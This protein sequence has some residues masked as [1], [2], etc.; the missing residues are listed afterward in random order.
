MWLCINLCVFLLFIQF[1]LIAHRVN[2]VNVF[3]EEAFRG[4]RG[5]PG[6]DGLPGSRGL[7]GD[8]GENGIDLMSVWMT[9]TLLNRLRENDESSCFFIRN[10]KDI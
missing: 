5:P 4:P 10:L 8:P 2:M 9:N 1:T 7:K 6:A 3:G